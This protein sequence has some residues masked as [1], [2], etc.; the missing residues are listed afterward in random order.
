MLQQQFV[1]NSGLFSILNY[2]SNESYEYPSYFGTDYSFDKPSMVPGNKTQLKAP[3]IVYLPSL[4][5]EAASK[6]TKSS[7]A[8]PFH[9]IPQ[10]TTNEE[11]NGR[12]SSVMSVELFPQVHMVEEAKCH[13]QTAKPVQH[14]AIPQI[15]AKEV[16]PIHQ[17]AK[18]VQPTSPVQ[19]KEVNTV[20]QSPKPVEVVPQA[21]EETKSRQQSANPVQE[22]AIATFQAKEAKPVQQADTLA[23]QAVIAQ[24][25]ANE[26]VKSR[27]PSAIPVKQAVITPVQ[28]NEETEYCQESAELVQAVDQV[29]VKEDTRYRQQSAKPVQAPLQVQTIELVKPIPQAAIPQ[30]QAIE[31]TRS[32]QQSAKPVQEAAIAQIQA[33]EG[34]RCRQHSAKP[35]EAASQI[36]GKEEVKSRQTSTESVPEAPIPQTQTIEEVKPRQQSAE[37]V[38]ADLTAQGSARPFSVS[39]AAKIQQQRSRPKSGTNR[40]KAPVPREQP[41][42]GAITQRHRPTVRLQP[43]MGFT[44]MQRLVQKKQDLLHTDIHSPQTSRNEL[45]RDL[46]NTA[47]TY[48]AHLLSSAGASAAV[49][50]QFGLPGP[51]PKAKTNKERKFSALR[52]R[53][54][55][56]CSVKL[57]A[58]DSKAAPSAF[59]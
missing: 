6:A 10:A 37:P 25:R 52:A 59:I 2:E 7:A 27:Q 19:A 45:Q 23:Q 29:Q 18:P 28:A 22:A 42:E 38:E 43:N 14:A 47:S 49:Y 39:V 46:V 16:K 40:K 15:Q 34:V 4:R 48:I 20:Q 51:S 30:V 3:K 21:K 56:L 12:Q 57:G 13:Q 17:T 44:T 9:L 33:E 53:P 11:V 36:Q 32:G 26:E 35:V 24:I 8:K 54:K 31:D 41:I 58:L 55:E 1:S 5:S 50:H